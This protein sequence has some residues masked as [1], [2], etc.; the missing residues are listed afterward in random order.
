MKA[1]LLS[2]REYSEEDDKKKTTDWENLKM[3]TP[4]QKTSK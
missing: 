2:Y 4:L 3:E 1:T